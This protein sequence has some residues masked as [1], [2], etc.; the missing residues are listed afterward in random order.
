MSY[1]EKKLKRDA[2]KNLSKVT[3]F[4]MR[5]KEKGQIQESSVLLGYS[6]TGDVAH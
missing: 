2:L 4:Q 6:G 5:N 1:T 3:L